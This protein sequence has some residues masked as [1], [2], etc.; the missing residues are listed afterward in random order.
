L[1][2]T[3]QNEKKKQLNDIAKETDFQKISSSYK[4]KSGHEILQ[5]IN[6][7]YPEENKLIIF[8]G[9]RNIQDS[10]EKPQHSENEEGVTLEE[11]GA[12]YNYKNNRKKISKKNKKIKKQ[13][14]K[15]SKKKKHSIRVKT[16][17]K[18]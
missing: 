9:C 18:K 5:K 13:N 3:W 17:Y 10:K 15:I 6:T 11:G 7:D 14:K 16:S 4:S 2:T 8:H 1:N 12:K